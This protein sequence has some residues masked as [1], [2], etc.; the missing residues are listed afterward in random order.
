MLNI[1]HIGVQLVG[2]DEATLKYADDLVIISSSRA[3]PHSLCL[4]IWGFM[5][6]ST[7]YKSYHDR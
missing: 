1:L 5:L 6:L 3:V 7:L 2:E 4:F